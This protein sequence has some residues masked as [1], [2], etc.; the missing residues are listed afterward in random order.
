MT[1]LMTV[2][3]CGRPQSD[4]PVPLPANSPVTDTYQP[5]SGNRMPR[6]AGPATMMR[7]PQVAGVAGLDACFIGVPFDIGTSNR[8]GARLAH[9]QIRAE[10]ALLRPYNMGTGAAP[11]IRSTWRMQP[12]YPSIPT[13]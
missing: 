2:L 8:P 5:L 9:R 10:S 12:A 1:T 13:T 4:S 6:F 7:L 11:S 3:R